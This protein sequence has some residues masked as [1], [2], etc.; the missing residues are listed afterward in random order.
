MFIPPHGLDSKEILS[1]RQILHLKGPFH[2]HVFIHQILRLEPPC[3]VTMQ[4]FNRIQNHP[5]GPFVRRRVDLEVIPFPQ[6]GH[7]QEMVPEFV[8][9]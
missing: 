3:L 9:E 4:Q 7:R 6:F 1:H 5:C 8:R 2:H